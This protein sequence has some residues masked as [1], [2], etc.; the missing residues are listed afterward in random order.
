M[1]KCLCFGS[2]K[3]QKALLGPDLVSF[4]T[5]VL[6]HELTWSQLA[7]PLAGLVLGLLGD[8]GFVHPHL[9]R[10]AIL[11][12]SQKG[13]CLFKRVRIV[14]ARITVQSRV[15]WGTGGYDAIVMMDLLNRGTGCDKIRQ[16]SKEH[17]WPQLRRI[18]HE[19]NCDGARAW[20]TCEFCPG[21]A[22]DVSCSLMDQ[23]I[24]CTLTFVRREVVRPGDLVGEISRLIELSHDER[25]EDMRSVTEILNYVVDRK[26]IKSRRSRVQKEH[27]EQKA[28]WVREH[29]SMYKYSTS[30]CGNPDCEHM[31]SPDCSFKTCSGCMQE[32]YCSEACQKAAWKAHKHLCGLT[33]R[34]G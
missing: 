7:L 13:A 29:Y 3:M 31:E 34:H 20:Y 15:S 11:A 16:L 26:E 4:A 32:R 1:A 14:L 2:V 5:W 12:A 25:L 22:H 21:S 33:A 27:D 10:D 19:S 18:I 9:Y 24:R 30:P 6:D 8:I 28:S 17:V 23:C